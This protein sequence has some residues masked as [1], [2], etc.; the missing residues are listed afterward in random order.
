MSGKTVAV[1]LTVGCLALAAVPARA[2]E[3]GV[4]GVA[5]V[6]FTRFTAVARDVVVPAGKTVRF[7]LDSRNYGRVSLL[8][9]GETRPQAGPIGLLTLFGPPL[10]PA[11]GPRPLPVNEDGRIAVSFVEPVLGP[12][13]V[14]AV[15]NDSQ[16]DARL[17]I[18]AYLAN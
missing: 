2:Q 8:I 5:V 10:V 11:S 3:Q 7:N 17:T 13:M 12:A 4:A 16:A 15:H 1:L 6:N 9:A 14:I 18:G